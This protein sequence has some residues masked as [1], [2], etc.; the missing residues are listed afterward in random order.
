MDMSQTP[1][2][3]T[4]D[5]LDRDRAERRAFTAAP[6]G[7]DRMFGTGSIEQRMRTV[8][9]ALAVLGA[10]NAFLALAMWL[11]V[12][13][14]PAWFVAALFALTAGLAATAW[15][16]QTWIHR[17]IVRPLKSAA[18]SAVALA[19]GHHE[20]TVENE[21]RDDEIGDIARAL[22]TIKKAAHK[23]QEL[24]AR[25]DT[26]RDEHL[27]ALRR[28][29]DKFDQTVGEIVGSVASASS[30]LQATATAMAASAEQ[31]ANQSAKVSSAL[32]EATAGVTAAAAASD[33]FA[34]SI[35]EIS[36]QASTSAELA[37]KASG[38]AVNAD[39]TISEL[40]TSASEVGKIV[41]LI[42]TIAQR[43]NLL[44]L[45]ASIEALSAAARP[46]AASRWWRPRSRSWRRR[47][48]R[49]PS[50]W[51][52]RSGRCRIR[53]PP[54]SPRCATSPSRSS[55]SRRPRCR[56]P[57]RSTSSRSPARTS[58]ARSTSPR[59]APRK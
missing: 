25:R 56:S 48:E 29:T 8:L 32:N 46:A 5:E 1:E 38:A 51:P 9:G 53:P 55:S 27:A 44:A 47:P 28:L 6:R 39:Q 19:D 36:R 12:E 54:A 58:P 14:A 15:F 31:S 2:V 18:H 33:E 21:H 57:R 22:V 4:V 17:D 40:T 52:G 16:A 42:S 13:G 10:G 20:V 49:Q 34:M 37:R 30:E 7:H 41:E 24:R 11:N 50:K 26:D 59:A 35:G 23:F 45:N 43:T 3:P